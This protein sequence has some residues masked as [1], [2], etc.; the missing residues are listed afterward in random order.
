M[1]DEKKNRV[2]VQAVNYERDR[3]GRFACRVAITIDPAKTRRILT[4]DEALSL[5]PLMDEAAAA[6]LADLPADPPL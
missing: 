5:L 3:N 4:L 6:G 1:S 2:H